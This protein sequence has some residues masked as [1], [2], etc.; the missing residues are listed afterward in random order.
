MTTITSPVS[1]ERVTDASAA[2]L[3]TGKA[4]TLL[5][6][7][8]L[9][10]SGDPL[11]V[12]ALYVDESG[13][14]TKRVTSR[15][16]SEASVAPG[17][18]V[19]FAT[20]FNAFPASYWRRWTV[21]Q[22]VVL[23]MRVSGPGR[24]D[25]YRSKADG[26]IIHVTGATTSGDE[27]V[28]EFELD[29][30]PFEDGGWYW[31][32]VTADDAPLVVHEASWSAAQ[33]P[34]QDT[35]LSIGICTYNRPTDCVAALAALA[36]DPVVAGVI[37][38]VIVADQ[39]NK[40]VR[41]DAGFAAASAGLGD[42][43][44]LVEQ[45]NLGGS[46]GFSRTMYEM[47]ENTD[48]T[49]HILLDD[50]VQLEPD[51]IARAYAFAR[52]TKAPM[53][54]GGQML[55][56]QD[57]SVLHTMGEVVARE[58]FFWRAAPNTE[59]AHDFAKE[60][61]RESP[62]LHRRIDVDYTGW[63]MCLIPRQ[64][65]EQL[66]LALPLF[67]KWD[68]AEYGIR[69]GEHGFPTATLPGVAVWH[70]SWSDK[71]DTA[72][73]Q[74]YFHTRNRLVAAALHTPYKR[75]GRLLLDTF[76]FDLKFLIMLQYA[77]AAL[78]HRAYE[79]FLAGPERL[80]PIL[81]TALPT[82]LEHQGD[83]PDGRVVGSSSDL[84]LPSMGAIKAEKFMKPPT[85]PLTIGRTLLAALVHNLRPPKADTAERPEINISAQDARWF[86]LSRLDSATVGTADGR[87]VTFR[88]REPDTFWRML[89]HSARVHVRLLREFPKLKKQYREH[90][91]QLTSPESWRQAFNGELR[92]E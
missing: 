74:A 51:S 79:D 80:F 48:A 43:L 40:K 33:A 23:G 87:G 53:L 19:S 15:S 45:G 22:T 47:L 42:K 64:A 37:S 8:L 39:G 12:R 81:P 90:M 18:E 41:D 63:W 71:D 78:H 11:K 56:L 36:D 86:L 32:D 60:S 9:P 2:D 29:L 49:H 30:T 68:D 82:A 7:V 20:Y 31:F 50:D 77:T 6:R 54:V 38:K 46:G 89:N 3:A 16:R 70:L 24:I 44:M 35:R 85:T 14:G 25:V 27:R 55:A 5:Q 28:L 69:A 83:Y 58:K 88:R 17:N 61:L 10:R 84:P 57:R 72:G 4:V 92:G 66:G 21:L 67:I 1:P 75:G 59:Y 76:K 62:D 65:I 26:S 13:A 52:F 34:Q 91:Q 73:W